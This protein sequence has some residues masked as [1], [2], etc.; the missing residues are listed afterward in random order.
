MDNFRRGDV[1]TVSGEGRTA[2]WDK[3]AEGTVVKVSRVRGK[4]D[5]QWHGS[6]VTD[7][8]SPAEL[9][10]TGRRNPEL[11]AR[12]NRE[13]EAGRQVLQS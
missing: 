8:M 12:L 4:V 5:V 2:R 13:R 6:F 1:V 7:E 3:S 10:K 9:R 11:I